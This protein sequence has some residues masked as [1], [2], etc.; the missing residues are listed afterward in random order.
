L[1][2]NSPQYPSTQV[3][4]GLDRLGMGPIRLQAKATLSDGRI[5]ASQPLRF[6]VVP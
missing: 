5:I 4:I 1:V 2:N 3:V 6:N